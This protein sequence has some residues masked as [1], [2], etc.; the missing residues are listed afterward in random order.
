MSEKVVIVLARCSHF[1][2]PF[3]IRFEQFSPGNWT[4]NWAFAIQE[5]SARKE[6]YDRN[7]IRG[8][9]GLDGAYPGCPHCHNRVL[10]K[11]G[12]GKLSC[13]DGSSP[14]F[15]CPWCGQ[16][17]KVIEMDWDSLSAGGD[18]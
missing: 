4:A 12:C 15:T 16:S 10:L 2:Q 3:G 5:K 14:S 6:G 18:R 13:Y 17:G 8:S 7:T 11:C 9:F 1:K